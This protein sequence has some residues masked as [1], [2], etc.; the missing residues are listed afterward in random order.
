MTTNISLEATRRRHIRYLEHISHKLIWCNNQYAETRG[1]G[2]IGVI[3]DV[4]GRKYS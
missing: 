4:S 2:A 3:D 1:N